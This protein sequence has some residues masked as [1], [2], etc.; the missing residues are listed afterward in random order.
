MVLWILAAIAVAVVLAGVA[1][2]ALGSEDGKRGTQRDTLTPAGG[3]RPWEVGLDQGTRLSTVPPPSGVPIPPTPSE[4]LDLFGLES[5]ELWLEDEE[6]TGPVPRISVSA[7]CRTDPG[8]ARRHNEDA[9]L[10]LPEYEVYA[11]ADGMGGYAAGE[12]AAASALET[13]RDAYE[14]E[15]YGEVEPGFPRRG[16]EL[17]AAVRRA[18]ERIR[19]ESE[20][21]ERKAG[22]GTTVVSTRFSPGRKRVYIA[23]VGDSR[24]YRLRDGRLKQLTT[25]HTLGAVGIT[26][27]SAGKLSRAV[28]VFE[29]VDVD[30]TVDEPLPGDFYLLCSDGLYKMVPEPTIEHIVRQEPSLDRAVDCLIAEANDRGGRDNVSVVL[31]RIDAPPFERATED[32]PPQA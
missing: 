29:D 23:H 10:V 30:L 11:I 4:E 16:A 13:L 2:L 22:M 14:R 18:N 9:V 19:R 1:H 26:G 8:R 25:D 12:V 21:D 6:P 3:V 20:R 24:C 15:D 28:G 32:A 5:A 17:M 27:P 7:A 31:I